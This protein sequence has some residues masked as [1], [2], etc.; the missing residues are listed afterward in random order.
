MSNEAEQRATGCMLVFLRWA[1][2]PFLCVSIWIMIQ[3]L[4]IN[5]FYKGFFEAL[6]GIPAI[7]QIFDVLRVGPYF[8]PVVFADSLISGVVSKVIVV[9][10]ENTYVALRG[11]EAARSE[12]RD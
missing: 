12:F 1:L 2:L 4:S 9:I 11:S 7:G 3:E 6:T 5:E 8:L 10:F